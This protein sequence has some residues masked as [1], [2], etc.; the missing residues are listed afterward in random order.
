MLADLEIHHMVVT[1]DG[2][3]L[4]LYDNGNEVAAITIT[5]TDIDDCTKARIGGYY[6]GTSYPA[7]TFDGTIYR[8]RFWNRVVDAKALFERADVAFA[9]Q[10]GSQ[11]TINSGTTTKGKR[12]RITAR[13]GV[14]F[15]TVGAANNNVGTE[16]L[17]TGSV[18]L[19]GNDTVAQLGCVS[20][21]DLAFANPTQSLTVQ[22]RA[23][24]A[25]GTTHTSNVSQVQPVVQLNSTSARIGPTAATPADG[26]VI[27]AKIVVQTADAGIGPSADADE[28]LLENT[29][30]AGMTILSGNT[31]DAAIY[32]GDGDAAGR[33]R[34]NYDNNDDSLKL[35]TAAATRLTISST[36]QVGIGKTPGHTLDI[37]GDVNIDA[38]HK[39]RWGGGN[40]EILGDGSYNLDFKTYDGSASTTNLTIYC[41]G[42]ATFGAKDSSEMGVTINGSNQKVS[43]IETVNSY[44]L[45]NC[46]T[47]EFEAPS[48]VFAIYVGDGQGALFF[49][50]YQSAT[51]TKLA[52]STTFVAGDAGTAIRVYT[53]GSDA[54][55]TVKN[56]K[57]SGSA[58]LKILSLGA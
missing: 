18:T 9:D 58:V 43:Q 41:A 39:L 37:D 36:G 14:D 54:T 35:Y 45:T 32:F 48:A 1:V 16:F 38:N 25:D 2:T 52:G 12:Y 55:V 17:A 5:A 33:G 15:T 51:V 28:L 24:A 29:G 27:A 4:K 46:S 42:V 11:T 19:D 44:T 10:Y 8:A 49:S 57:T 40:A 13:D 34:V 6:E 23:G 56:S 26:E 47:M 22:D 30:N 53:A 3:A 7:E 21:Y 50:E 20:D 31:S